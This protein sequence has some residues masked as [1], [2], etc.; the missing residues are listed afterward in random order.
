MLIAKVNLKNSNEIKLELLAPAGGFEQLEAAINFGADAVYLGL[1]NFS[2]RARAKNFSY[3][4]L[5]K[6]V[7]F[8]HKSGILVYVTINTMI[9]EGDLKALQEAL[10]ATEQMLLLLVIWRRL[11]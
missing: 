2:M 9:K 10:E 1:Q 8:C 3:D 7:E 11:C 4:E 5:K 6:A